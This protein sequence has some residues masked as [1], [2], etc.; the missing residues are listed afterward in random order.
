MAIIDIN[1][2]IKE[3]TNELNTLFDEN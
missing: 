1:L 2:K 3:L